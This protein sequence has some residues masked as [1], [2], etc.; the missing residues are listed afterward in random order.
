MAEPRGR[1]CGGYGFEGIGKTQE[2]RAMKVAACMW[3]CVGGGT[4]DR[5][6][7][8]LKAV[9]NEAKSQT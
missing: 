1:D 5:P 8:V 4:G 9:R 3:I 2:C 7:W 6:S